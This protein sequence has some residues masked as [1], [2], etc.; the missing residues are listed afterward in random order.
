MNQQDAP[1]DVD[2]DLV[3]LLTPEGVRVSD[4]AVAPYAARVAHL[5]AAALRELY[6]D[7][8]L[9]RRFDT[10][11]TS[12]QRQGELGLFPQCLGQEAAQVGS[13][14]ALAPQDYVFPSY[15][16]H[17][18]AFTRGL[19]LAEILLQFRG[20]DHGG[21]DTEKHNFHLYTLVI[22]SHTLHATG[23][24][25][26]LQRDGLVGTGDPERDTA[27]VAYF[28]DGATSQG[29]VNEALV[30]AATTNAP[31][32]FFCQNNQWA[33]SEPTTRQSRVPLFH[34]GRGFGIP[35]VRVDGNDV[36]ASYAVMDEALE[37]ARS[38]GGPTFVE[39]YTYRMGAHTTSDDPTRYRSR[40]EE[41]HWRRRDPI[42]RLAALL[43]AEGA[44]DDAWAA[45]VEAEADGLGEHLR[46]YVRAI[47]APPASSMFDHVYASEHG[48]VSAERAW[49]AEYEAS[50]D[51]DAAAQGGAR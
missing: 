47:E 12:L 45:D 17:G 46:T 26:G 14:R 48:T 39:A 35:S 42:D 21:W 18:V 43:R 29:D 13:G 20:V 7:M 22:G 34:R 37:R 5:D 15:R 10:E 3:Q 11:S 4:E 6:H 16:E 44:W 9:V 36:L 38:G 41:E 27:V 50:F 51:V 1:A 28:G 33:I 31:V 8:V 32:V 40:S 19:D 49:H 25:M 23:Y 24:G 30:F 2:P